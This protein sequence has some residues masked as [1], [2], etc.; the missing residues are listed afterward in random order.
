MAVAV[1]G[2]L[3]TVTSCTK[4]CDSGY[5]G[6]DCKTE[7]RT[8][9]LKVGA[10]VTESCSGTSSPAY[11]VDVVTGSDVTKIRIKNLGNYNCSTGDYYVVLSVVDG[12]NLNIDAQTVCATVWSGTAVY[13]ASANTLT[14][15]YTATYGSP[16]VTDQC[17]ATIAL[18]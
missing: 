13:N 1:I 3:F 2:T 5:E 7:I 17:T 6:S 15:N 11:V 14:V 4:T 10:N 8:K 16:S 12:T 9:L 18:N